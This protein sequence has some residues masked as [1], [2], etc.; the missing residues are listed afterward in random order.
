MTCKELTQEALEQPEIQ[1]LQELAYDG[2]PEEVC[3]NFMHHAMDALDR[4]IK[5]YTKG[6][7]QDKVE[8]ERAMHFFNEAFKT[9]WKE[10]QLQFTLYLGRAKLN[11]LIAQFKDCK[12]DCLAALKIK[13]DDITMW[14]TLCRSRFFVEKWTEGLKYANQGLQVLPGNEKL[15]KWKAAFEA[16]LANEKKIASEI[17]TLNQGKEDERMRVYRALRA[18]KIKVGKRLHEVPADV[19]LQIELDIYKKLHFPVL[20]LY[21]EFMCTDFIQDWEQDVTLRAALS[22]VFAEQPPWDAE[23]DY[24]MQTIEVYYEA[25]QTKCLDPR[26]T[27]KKKSTKKY[28]RCNLND[29]LLNI[30]T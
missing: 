25:D 18:H 2:T 8:C 23:G 5:K 27:P 13:S 26:E 21:D 7:K 11:L 16:E 10:Y 9:G 14:I 19:N 12:D 1:A 20:L 29:T 24:T 28:I 30:V 22:P 15:L 17:A 4:V 3:R 6:E